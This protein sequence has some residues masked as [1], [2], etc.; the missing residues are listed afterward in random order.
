MDPVD[1]YE[2]IRLVNSKGET[3]ELNSDQLMYLA[4]LCNQKAVETGVNGQEREAPTKEMIEMLKQLNIGQ[5]LT[6]AQQEELEAIVTGGLPVDAKRG[7]KLFKDNMV[8]NS[9]EF[10]GLGTLHTEGRA[11]NYA[12]QDNKLNFSSRPQNVQKEDYMQA[13]PE[14]GYFS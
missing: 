9:V 4:Q 1:E 3:I 14:F 12:P 2:E 7:K 11:I 6:Q 5:G 13:N 8:E 10:K